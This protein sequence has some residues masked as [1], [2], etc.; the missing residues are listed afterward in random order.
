M[1]RKIHNK[2]SHANLRKTAAQEHIR[3]INEETGSGMRGSFKIS[4]TDADITEKKSDGAPVRLHN[5]DKT[6]KKVLNETAVT[7]IP[8][9]I[10]VDNKVTKQEIPS[11][12][13]TTTVFTTKST[14]AMTK[15]DVSTPEYVSTTPVFVRN[16]FDAEPWIPILPNMPPFSGINHHFLN[17][18]RPTTS[19]RTDKEPIYTSFTNPGLSSRYNEEE[20]LGTTHLRSHPLPVNKIPIT[21]AILSENLGSGLPSDYASPDLDVQ[22]NEHTNSKFIEIETL[23][24]IPQIS[25]PQT[26]IAGTNDANVEE[27]SKEV[28]SEEPEVSGQGQVEVVIDD[29]Y[30][31]LH[32]PHT[33]KIPLVTLLPVKSNSGIGRPIR[34]R[35]NEMYKLRTS[36]EH[37]TFSGSSEVI[38][39]AE[40]E[41]SRDL[42]FTNRDL[43][44]FGVLNF[45]P[46]HAEEDVTELS[47]TSRSPKMDLELMTESGN[48]TFLSSKRNYNSSYSNILT[49]DEL[50]QLAQIS[51][52]SDKSSSVDR[53]SDFSFS[54]KAVSSSSSV[55]Q[56][57]IPLL[58]KPFNLT[59][60]SGS[61]ETSFEDTGRYSSLGTIIRDKNLNT[62][63]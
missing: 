34:K 14:T 21:E 44:I 7:S 15:Q 22:L 26:V 63:L 56:L 37:R 60:V 13:I 10:S 16:P 12:S 6:K 36:G 30:D 46:E 35:P 55:N 29:S 57:P 24:H 4:K 54:T 19:P 11:S 42:E 41:G 33:T 40:D 47:S 45:A 50:K 51:K 53:N 62:K 58:K 9:K 39:S 23:E 59:N 61:S 31:F 38:T 52:V 27:D 25:K 20:Y 5:I 28:V 49:V 3:K 32:T 43:K 18:I 8:Y 2:T 1:I 48:D 17:T